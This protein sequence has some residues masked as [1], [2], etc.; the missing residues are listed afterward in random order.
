ME[1]D[2]GDTN[3]AGSAADS[4]W[5]WCHL[6]VF[7]HDKPDHSW[8]MAFAAKESLDKCLESVEDSVKAVVPIQQ[9]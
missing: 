7:V 1:R 5:R 2:L 3:N 9:S 6:A 4:F 8:P